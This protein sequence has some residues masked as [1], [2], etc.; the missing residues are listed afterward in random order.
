VQFGKLMDG[1]T[2]FYDFF[3]NFSLMYINDLFYMNVT[4]LEKNMNEIRWLQTN[5][6][7]GEETKALY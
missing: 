2:P 7:Y 4:Q 1:M 6:V 5:K 3:F